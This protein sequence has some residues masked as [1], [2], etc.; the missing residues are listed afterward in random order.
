MVD[1]VAKDYM[2]VGAGVGGVGVAGMAIVPA[3]A[4]LTTTMTM[5]MV[6][7]APTT[8]AVATGWGVVFTLSKVVA[9]IGGAMFLYGFGRGV[10]R[11]VSAY[12]AEHRAVK[13][14]QQ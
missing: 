10:Y 13:I 2:L 14:E 9:T 4:P 12:R 7:T 11:G 8:V 6:G 3:G 1:Q 5:G